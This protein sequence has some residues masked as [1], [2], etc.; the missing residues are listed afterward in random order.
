METKI[1]A[2]VHPLDAASAYHS[3]R[4]LSE[5]TGFDQKACDEIAIV[6]SELATNQLKYANGG[7]IKFQILQDEQPGLQI[8]AVDY[9]PGIQD[10]DQ[11]MKDGFSTAGS[12]GLGLGTVN[13]LMDVMEIQSHP[14][15]GVQIVCKRWVQPN[16][17]DAAVCPIDIGVATRPH[18]MM[19][20]NGDAFIIK[21][22]ERSAL[23]GIVDGLGH[24]PLAN[25]AAQTARQYVETHFDQPLGMI[26]QG[27][28]WACKATRGVVMAL[29]RID[30]PGPDQVGDFT[31][32]NIRRS[33]L[34][35]ADMKLTFASLG[36]IESRF[37]TY[38]KPENFIIRRGVIGLNAPNAVVT[39]HIWGNE[40]ILVLH[41]DGISIHW[42]KEQFPNLFQGS[43]SMA[44]QDLMRSLAKDEDDATVIIVKGL[45]SGGS[46]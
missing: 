42:Q 41:S 31:E 45:R 34:R 7:T 27:T 10:I 21:R 24:G 39:T 20:V 16:T 18:P 2:I 12:L 28:N 3:A 33:E 5:K 9:G 46:K 19:T 36:N 38:P 15:Q 22:W 43:A 25:L 4:E 13:R 6:V 1:I 23:I 44:A 32:N 26:F 17:K 11:A 40:S 8:E 29:A 37:F 14:G 30:D 35:P